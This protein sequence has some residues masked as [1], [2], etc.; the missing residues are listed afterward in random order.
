MLENYFSNLHVNLI[1]AAFTKCPSTWRDMD[2]IPDYN[3]F[4]FICN[5]EGML[6]VGTQDFILNRTALPDASSIKQS[7][8]CI[9]T[10]TF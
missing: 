6:K 4:Y 9:N 2:Y 5:G 8:S 7:Y 1:V 3:K 10:N